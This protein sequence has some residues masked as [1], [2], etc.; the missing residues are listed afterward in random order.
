MIHKGVINKNLLFEMLNIEI[1][2]QLQDLDRIL[3]KGSEVHFCVGNTFT[4][5]TRNTFMRN[6][7]FQNKN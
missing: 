2:P 3:C 5:T 1:I 6:F 4:F 7:F